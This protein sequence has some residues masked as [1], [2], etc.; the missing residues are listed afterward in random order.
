MGTFQT[1]SP[2]T[3]LSLDQCEGCPGQH[4]ASLKRLNCDQH[5]HHFQFRS[6]FEGKSLFKIY[7]WSKLDH[8]FIAGSFTCCMVRKS[9]RRWRDSFL[10]KCL[11]ENNF[12][13]S[14]SR[15]V[16]AQLSERRRWQ[17]SI[18]YHSFQNLESQFS[19]WRGWQKYVRTKRNEV[20]KSR[21]SDRLLLSSQRRGGDLWIL[22]WGRDHSILGAVQIVHI[23]VY[24]IVQ[25]TKYS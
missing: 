23:S 21:S 3:F 15:L 13:N 6:G 8:G 17:K 4:S 9:K 22:D 18:K 20:S 5:Y 16:V 12:E 25:N 24:H 14:K 11:S 10:A 1:P 19:D 7:L 2:L